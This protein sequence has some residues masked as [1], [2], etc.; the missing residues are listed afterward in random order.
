MSFSG[1]IMFLLTQLFV[2]LDTGWTEITCTLT[3]KKLRTRRIATRWK[4]RTS[5]TQ[6]TETATQSRQ[7]T[8][9]SQSPFPPPSPR[10]P[11]CPRRPASSTCGGSSSSSWW[12]S[13]SSSSSSSSTTTAATTRKSSTPVSLALQP[14]SAARLRGLHSAVIEYC[15]YFSSW[16]KRP[17]ERIRSGARAL[18]E[19]LA[20]VPA[21]VR[22]DVTF[23]CRHLSR[24]CLW[25]VSIRLRHVCYLQLLLS[26]QCSSAIILCSAV[27][28]V[29][30]LET[31]TRDVTAIMAI[32]LTLHFVGCIFVEAH[33]CVNAMCISASIKTIQYYSYWQ[34]P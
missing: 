11:V 7:P 9:R 14:S 13:S 27:F 3:Q 30:A 31:N 24:S 10:P 4:A 16:W 8:S 20:G 25:R 15:S 19:E 22:A 17:K 33:S 34:Y 29:V 2:C 32:G 28:V 26:D 18:R 5:A 6:P 1:Y 12:S 21:Q 23:C